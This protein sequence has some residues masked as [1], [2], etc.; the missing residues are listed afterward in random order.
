MSLASGY[1][2]LLISL[3]SCSRDLQEG[4]LEKCQ[5]LSLHT[6]WEISP[7]GW[8]FN[9]FGT[10]LFV[11]VCV[12]ASVYVWEDIYSLVT[13]PCLTYTTA[14]TYVFPCIHMKGGFSNCKNAGKESW[15]WQQVLS[16]GYYWSLSRLPDH[17][18]RGIKSQKFFNQVFKLS[19]CL[20][21]GVQLALLPPQ[22][23]I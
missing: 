2:K 7:F 9:G 23:M 16:V 8:D 22:I 3:C 15:F 6:S 12:C 1:E 19:C 5:G 11:S 17:L 10:C 14:N 4:W 20:T 18:W 13:H 21:G